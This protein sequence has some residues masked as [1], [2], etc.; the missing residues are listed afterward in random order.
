MMKTQKNGWRIFLIIGLL[1][2]IPLLLAVWFYTHKTWLP[3][4]SLNHGQLIN[5][6][7]SLEQLSI[8]PRALQHRW[9]ILYIHTPSCDSICQKDLY[10]IRQ[11][12][13]ALGKDTNRLQRV[14]VTLQPGTVDAQLQ[15]ELMESQTLYWRIDPTQFAKV[16]GQTKTFY[17]VDPLGNIVLSY[18]TDSNPEWILDDLKYLMG[19][20]SIG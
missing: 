14:F 7:P 2:L 20:S 6:P 1:F 12:Q 9:A 19:V 10:N 15:K 4:R 8:N 13:R 3:S 11:I 16:L 17:V 5:P 18:A